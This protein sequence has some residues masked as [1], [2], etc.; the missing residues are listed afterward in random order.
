MEFVEPGLLSWLAVLPILAML[1]V[2]SLHNRKRRLR[3][4][5]S[6]KNLLNLVPRYSRRRHLAKILL[7]VTGAGLLIVGLA[8]PRWG[9]EWKEV[10]RTGVDIM[11]ALDVSSSMQAEDIKPNRLQRAR[12]EIIDLIRMLQGDRI[13]LI[14][15]A[16]VG[17]VQCP[18]TVDYK[19]VQMFLN[20]LDQGLIPINGTSLGDAI[21]LGTKSLTKGSEANSQGKALIL[22]TDG[23]D[24]N[25]QPL[26]AA[27]EAKEKGVKV[28]TIGM[29]QV[30][31]APIP[32][33]E[34]GFKKN[35]KG[36][37]VVTK[38][39]EGTLIEI[40]R[41]TGGD[42]VRSTTGDLDLER[43]YLNGIRG[44]LLEEGE[45][46]SSRQKLWYERSHLFSLAAFILLL[47]S[48]MLNETVPGKREKP[49]ADG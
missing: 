6:A 20:H 33:P 24:Q 28:F 41:L 45:I 27:E 48:F 3:R 11:I 30:G 9:F 46:A 8:R 21:R 4:F 35:Q 17:F 10:K 43:I 34:G 23:E 39:D 22:I 31:G 7:A 15:F 16:G 44:G 1:Y 19:A 5:V 14:A 40:A 13:G 26:V 29:G 38:L 12:R 25:S 42:Y 18:L 47:G 49:L 37:V 32:L 36:D 2:L